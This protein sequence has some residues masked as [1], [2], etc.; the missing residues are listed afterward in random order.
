M[1]PVWAVIG[2]ILYSEEVH[3]YRQGILTRLDIWFFLWSLDSAFLKLSQGNWIFMDKII[4][5]IHW[6][7]LLV[8]SIGTIL[9][10]DSP[11]CY[12]RGVSYSN[13]KSVCTYS[14]SRRIEN[15]GFIFNFLRCKM[16]KPLLE[17]IF[18]I[19]ELWFHCI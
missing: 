11:I 13:V 17:F 9:L 4:K 2:N 19:V 5:F 7:Y 16:T 18:L 6:K 14:E 3:L 15:R 8:Y 12:H 10:N 1:Y